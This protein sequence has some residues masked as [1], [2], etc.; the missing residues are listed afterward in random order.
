VNISTSKSLR[1]YQYQYPTVNEWCSEKA[2]EVPVS[3]PINEWV[4][5]KRFQKCQKCFATFAKNPK[6]MFTCDSESSFDSSQSKSFLHVLC[7]TK[8]NN[9]RYSQFEA[10]FKANILMN[11]VKGKKTITHT[12]SLKKLH[13]SSH[14]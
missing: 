13:V 3:S 2:K 5:D 12:I 9:F 4:I 14:F 8:W 7:H 6:N 11:E 10:L 1:E